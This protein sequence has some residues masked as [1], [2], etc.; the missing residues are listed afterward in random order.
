MQTLSD[1]SS[2][3]A[4]DVM[5]ALESVSKHNYHDGET[6]ES[7]AVFNQSTGDAIYCHRENYSKRYTFTI[8][9]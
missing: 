8:N 6:T 4:N 5:S 2:F 1:K 3:T 9:K 7:S